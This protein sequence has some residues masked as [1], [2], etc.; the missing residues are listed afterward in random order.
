MSV[1]DVTTACLTRCA[2][3]TCS[4]VAS[5]TRTVTR[6]AG[7]AATELV[8]RLVD[9]WFVNMGELY[10]KPREEVTPEEKAASFRYQIMDVGRSGDWIPGLWPR[11]RDGL[12]AQHARL[13][14]QQEALLR[15][16]A[17][18]LR[19]RRVR[20]FPRRRQPRRVAGTR[21][22]RVGDIRRTYAASTVHRRRQN[23][24]PELRRN[25][26]RIDDVGNPWLD[27][28]IVGIS[29]L[30]Y[31]SDRDYWEKWYPADWISESFPGQFRNWF[32]SLLAQST[33][34]ADRQSW[35]VQEPV[36]LRA[37]SSPKMGARCTRAGA[38]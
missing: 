14:D 6:T 17:A 38:T 35:P 36:Q 8:Y 7:A 1:F 12:A 2:K 5:V 31:S 29:T 9:E 34:M 10:D 4:I 26:E 22:R 18:D 3:A 32:Y 25:D 28:G 27:A 23:R 33:L 16:G 13:D 30:H 24:L 19:M 37:R 20:S 15:S 21:G 11:S